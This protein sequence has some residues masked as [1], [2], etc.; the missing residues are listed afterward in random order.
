MISK[1]TAYHWW[2][3]SFTCRYL[4][5]PSQKSMTRSREWTFLIIMVSTEGEVSLETL[6]PWT[7]FLLLGNCLTL[8]L[9]IMCFS[10]Y[11]LWPRLDLSF[12]WQAWPCSNHYSQDFHLCSISL[13]PKSDMVNE[14]ILSKIMCLHSERCCQLMDIP[15]TGNY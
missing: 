9:F 14:S 8:L 3:S 2:P 4:S 5:M 1:C 6:R 15:T 7:F 10:A 11:D 12:G 13:K